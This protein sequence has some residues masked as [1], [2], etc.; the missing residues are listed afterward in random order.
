MECV[1][2]FDDEYFKAKIRP[3]YKFDFTD[4]PSEDEMTYFYGIYINNGKSIQPLDYAITNARRPDKNEIGFKDDFIKYLEKH[5][6]KTFKDCLFLFHLYTSY[7]A[8]V[9]DPEGKDPVP[10][11]SLS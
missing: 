2:P 11:I 9:L 3:F 10:A 8:T 7:M 1:F 5:K 4:G 6:P